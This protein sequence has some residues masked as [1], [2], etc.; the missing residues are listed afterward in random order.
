MV[1]AEG[2]APPSPEI[3]QSRTPVPSRSTRP[4]AQLR[5]RL[6]RSLAMTPTA[7]LKAAEDR[8]HPSRLPEICRSLERTESRYLLT[9]MIAEVLQGH[10]HPI[11]R[12]ELL[13]KRTLENAVRILTGLET[14][15]YV[16]VASWLPER[17]LDQPVTEIPGSPGI[18]LYGT[19]G[20]FRY[21]EAEQRSDQVLLGGVRM[22]LMALGDLVL[23]RST[24]PLADPADLKALQLLQQ[25]TR[26]PNS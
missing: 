8:S 24:G 1:A 16:Q 12:V 10:F 3:R 14:A 7:R 18:V 17:L 25:L 9:G 11:R 21:D 26:H 13:M 15:G 6:N 20:S 19:L 23:T 2:A 4:S 5:D 22:P